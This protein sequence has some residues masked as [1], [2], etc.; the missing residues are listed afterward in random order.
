MR[1]NAEWYQSDW[2][3][4]VDGGYRDDDDDDGGGSDEVC[5]VVAP[6]SYCLQ[7]IVLR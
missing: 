5:D 6:L 4:G 3:G 7:S 2:R 1:G